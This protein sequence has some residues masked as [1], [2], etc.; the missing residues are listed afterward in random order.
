MSKIAHIFY[1]L[2]LTS[3]IRDAIKVAFSIE[4]DAIQCVVTSA[5]AREHMIHVLNEAASES[6]LY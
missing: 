4:H 3:T 5:A 6:Y 2:A 1:Y